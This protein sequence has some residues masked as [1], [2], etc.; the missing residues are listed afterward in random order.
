[1]DG[2][3]PFQS[4][5][6]SPPQEPYGEYPMTKS[7][8]LALGLALAATAVAGAAYAQHAGKGASVTRAEAQTRAEQ[9]FARLDA[10][11]D[12]K[13][14]QT[15]RTARR[16]AMFDRIDADHNGQ[17]SRAEFDAHH[18]GGPGMHRAHRGGRGMGAG[19]GPMAEARKDG[20]V[21]QAEFTSAALQRFD[22]ADANKD[23]T[24]TA[25][26]RRAARKS[27]RQSMRAHRQ[28]HAGEHDHAG[29]APKAD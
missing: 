3:L 2:L 22:R 7:R 21:T 13:L 5:A 10:N 9:Q 20:A 15:D 18:A 23:G 24:V 25:E 27:Q 12:G 29:A 17:I 26:E 8:N 4:P 11:R 6:T 14:D 16:A 1:M 19:A 28:D